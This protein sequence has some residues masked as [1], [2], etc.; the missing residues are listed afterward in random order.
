MYF[1][2]ISPTLRP[3][4]RPP[5]IKKNEGY[6]R[7][8]LAIWPKIIRLIAVQANNPIFAGLNGDDISIWAMIDEVQDI[9]P[10][11]GNHADR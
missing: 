6:Q 7:K 11:G 3:L 5:N 1:P 8:L 2:E 9:L 10:E 4:D